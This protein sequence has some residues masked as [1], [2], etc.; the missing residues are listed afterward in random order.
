MSWP[1]LWHRHNRRRRD[2]L[3]LELAACEPPCEVTVVEERAP[4]VAEDA[5]HAVFS[6]IQP[7]RE[8]FMAITGLGLDADSGLP[9]SGVH[10]ASMDIPEMALSL[11]YLWAGDPS[12]KRVL[13]I[14]GSP[15]AGKEWGSFL[16]DVPSGQHRIALDRPGFGLT[17]AGEPHISLEAQA[18]AFRPLIDRGDGRKSILVGYSYGGPVAL[19]AAIDL[20][21]VVSGV[22]L[23][24]SAADPRQEAVHPLQALMA[25][26][27]FAQMLPRQLANANAELLALFGELEKLSYQLH[28]LD[29]PVTIVHGLRDNLVPSANVF[30]LSR[31]LP[32]TCTVR[33]M[34]VEEGDHF[35]PWTHPDK[36][37]EA[38]GELLGQV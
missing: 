6:P 10:R 34:L 4:S 33:I 11:S 9:A 1:R 19:K 21:E 32:A 22:L 2:E 26:E 38:L 13:F 24:G 7:L 23:V 25:L 37:N 15:G 36:L 35:L 31:Q 12:G 17:R 28:K 16:A 20:P 18:R 29:I 8:Q 5:L 30:Y 3:L 27:I 14:H